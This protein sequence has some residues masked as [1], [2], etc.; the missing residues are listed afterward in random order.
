MKKTRLII[1]FAAV[2]AVSHIYAQDYYRYASV[3]DTQTAYNLGKGGYQLSFLAYNNGGIEWKS[4]V[5]LTDNFFLGVSLDTEHMIGK[6]DISPNVPGVVLKLRLTDGWE[7]WPV[8]VSIGYDSFYMGQ[9]GKAPNNLSSDGKT[10]NFEYNDLNKMIYGPYFVITKPLYTFNS[11][12]HFSFGMR[13]PTQPDY[14][15]IDSTYFFSLDIPLGWAFVI[16]GEIER[17]YWDFR[18]QENWLA[19][20][21]LR[22]NIIDNLGFDF[23]FRFESGEKVNRVFRMEYNNE[24]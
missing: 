12:Q 7:R 16:K 10:S 13:L 6:E 20:A 18:R 4:F 19:N 3:I 11:E 24:F 17:V 14:V 8:S 22:F 2:F 9:V 1:I 23:C 5:G 21:G 15:P